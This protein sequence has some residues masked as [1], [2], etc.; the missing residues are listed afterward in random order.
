[1]SFS[2]EI[3]EDLS[4]ITNYKDKKL[5]EA[6]CFGFLLTGNTIHG[7]DYIEYS[8]ENEFI[9][10][11]LYK[12]LFNLGIDY[13]PD[14]DGKEY[15]AKITKGESLK[16]IIRFDTELKEAEEKALVRGSFLG[17][18]NITDPNKQYHLEILFNEKNNGE[19][20]IN[21]CRKYGIEFKM[22]ENRE[23]YQIYLKDSDNISTFL[24]LIESNKG[25]LAFEDVRLTKEVKNNVNRLVNCETANLNK[26]INASV[27]QINDIKFLQKLRKFD[28]L[29]EEL[30]EI[31]L[32]RLENPDASLKDLGNMLEKPL[33][34]SGVNHRLQR[35]HE[36]AEE[37]R[38]GSV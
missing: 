11:K 14:I 25:V 18:G 27:N 1:M 5:L 31:A 36:I 9:I 30:K 34:K 17:G 15:V 23:K 3:K 29:P 7:K 38:K 21:I 26:V 19:F 2:Y 12:L 24:A 22:I 10:E 6:E 13:E 4:K 37:Y 33:G 16:S 20:I 28:E 8:T 32:A 35:I